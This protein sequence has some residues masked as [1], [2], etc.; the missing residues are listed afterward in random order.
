MKLG[1]SQE[2]IKVEKH[3]TDV[4]FSHFSRMTDMKV[5][6]NSELCS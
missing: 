6:L 1:I 4:V 5:L 2:N 3:V